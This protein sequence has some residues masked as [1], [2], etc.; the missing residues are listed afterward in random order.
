[1]ISQ[2]RKRKNEVKVEVM[3]FFLEVFLTSFSSDL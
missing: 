3:L 2:K 1:M